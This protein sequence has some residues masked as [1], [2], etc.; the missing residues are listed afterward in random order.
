VPRDPA[1]I[2]A[3]AV[4]A[5]FPEAVPEPIPDPELATAVAVDGAGPLLLNLS[6]REMRFPG[7]SYFT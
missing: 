5:P 3:E 2:G 7:A 4:P 6:Q 1:T